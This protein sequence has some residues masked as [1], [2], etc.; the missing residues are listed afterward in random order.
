MKQ[1]PIKPVNLTPEKVQA[2]RQTV[3]QVVEAK[4]DTPFYLVDVA[5]DK[6]LGAWYLRL[7]VEKPDYSISLS[8]CETISRALDE[9]I[10]NIKALQDFPYSLEISSPGLFR[11]LNQEREFAFYKDQQV[12][13]IREGLAPPVSKN[14]RIKLPVIEHEIA[15]GILKNYD[16]SQ[17]AITLLKADKQEQTYVL[18]ADYRVFLN[19]DIRLP[20]I[21]E[22]GVAEALL[23]DSDLN[24]IDLLEDENND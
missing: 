3:F 18:E 24:P 2:I 21:E 10:D 1:T 7:Y 9:H 5:L 23:D 4:L 13:L 8:D 17:N 12:R 6:E 16:V 15:T 11:A 22:V 20:D 14:R 19:P